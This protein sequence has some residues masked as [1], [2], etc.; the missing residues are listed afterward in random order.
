MSVF[1]ITNETPIIK[2]FGLSNQKM[3]FNSTDYE[4]LYLKNKNEKGP[5]WY[6][7]DN[8]IEYKFNSWGYRTKEFDDLDK[9]YL[10][11]FGCSYTEG[12]GL[13]Y[14]DMWST[15][16]SKT[17]NIDLFNLGAGGTSPDF[18][19][20]NTIL[21]FNHVLKLNKL[22]R[23]VV[24]QWPEIHRIVYAFKTDKHNEIEFQPFTG[25]IPEEWYPQNSLEYGKWYHHSYL[26]NRGELIKNT[27]FC[28]MT[29]DA[30]W[31]SA[32]VK[33]LHWTYSTDFKMIHKESFIS[34][35]VDLINIID[36]SQ[37]KARDCS[38][39]GKESQDIVIKYLLK[40][41]N[42]NGIG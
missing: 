3:Y 38:H 13:H 15:K 8:E 35:N 9:D 10:L 39:N 6:Y 22:P 29:V 2:N 12:I 14:D 7:Y 26:E 36:D 25:A 24:Y 16:L 1:R 37:G 27:N 18:Q 28:P 33:V 31:K 42:F 20:Y 4:D 34:N 30:L 17:L 23:L 5:D 40:K 41:L 32:G 11:T 19:M 21:F